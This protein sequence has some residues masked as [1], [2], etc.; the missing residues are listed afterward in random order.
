MKFNSD[1]VSKICNGIPFLACLPAGELSEIESLV[2]VRTFSKNQTIL[3]ENEPQDY[4]YFVITGRV[5]VIRHSKEGKELLLAIHKKYDYFGE[6]AILD[7]KTAPATVVAMESS[8]IGFI[9]RERFMRCILTNEQSLH[10]LI[11]L[12]CSRLRDAWTVVNVM[13]CAEAGDKVRAALKI[14]SQKFGT[15]TKSGVIIS[16][17]ITHQDLANFAAVSRE[18]ASRILSAMAKTGEIEIIDRKYIL[19]TPSFFKKQP[20]S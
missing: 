9:K 18:T 14:F 5:K 15:R 11:S 3:L 13:G 12:L 20:I 10:E 16:T 19:L 6:M 8:A 4:F 17:K 7:G 1:V 2:T